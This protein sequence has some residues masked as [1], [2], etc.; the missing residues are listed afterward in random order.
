[1]P[2]LVLGDVT[3][4]GHRYSGL[5]VACADVVHVRLSSIAATMATI[6]LVCIPLLHDAL[7]NTFII[8]YA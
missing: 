8:R 2:T 7:L 6:K 3:I 5:L 4:F 1:V